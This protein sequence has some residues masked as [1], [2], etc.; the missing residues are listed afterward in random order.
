MEMKKAPG[1][2]LT[3]MVVRSYAHQQSAGP[4]PRLGPPDTLCWLPVL[5]V[6]DGQT[7]FSFDLPETPA[8]YRITAQAHTLTGRLGATEETL[9][10]Q[11]DLSVVPLAP[12]ELSAGDTFDLTVSVS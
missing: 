9:T 11:R 4:G 8:T 2:A 6:P 12:S 1:T 7:T 3:P 5:V 10:A